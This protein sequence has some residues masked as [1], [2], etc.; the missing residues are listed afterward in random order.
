MYSPGTLM[1]LRAGG[2]EFPVEATISQVKTE[3]ETLFTVILRDISVRK[4]TEDELRQAQKMEAVGHLA[5]GIAHE[6]NNYLGVIMGYS[7]LLA[8]DESQNESVCQT[9]AEINT[10]TAGLQPQADSRIHCLGPEQVHKR[11][12]Q[13]S[14]PLDPG[15]H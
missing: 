5:G 9:V 4:R 3:S 15:E 7:D 10:A 8:Q 1:G 2:E 13:A 11:D 6:F 12:P 14:T